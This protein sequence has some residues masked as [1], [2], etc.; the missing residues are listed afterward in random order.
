M[1]ASA[2]RGEGGRTGRGREALVGGVAEPDAGAR[3][4]CCRTGRALRHGRGVAGA[5]RCVDVYWHGIGNA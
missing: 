1:G 4:R 5:C 2:W 3:A